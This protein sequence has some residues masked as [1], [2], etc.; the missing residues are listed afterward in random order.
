MSYG[1]V[2]PNPLAAKTIPPPKFPSYSQK[3]TN[4]PSFKTPTKQQKN[5]KPRENHTILKQKLN[6]RQSTIKAKTPTNETRISR[7]CAGGRGFLVNPRAPRTWGYVHTC[8]YVLR[9]YVPPHDPTHANVRD[10]KKKR[11]FRYGRGR[12]ANRDAIC[13]TCSPGSKIRTV[14]VVGRE[15]KGMTRGRALIGGR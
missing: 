11:K 3:P 7:V 14:G 4:R 10:K 15:A 1:I 9:T 13:I 2:I 5:P 8:C 12:R 6:Q